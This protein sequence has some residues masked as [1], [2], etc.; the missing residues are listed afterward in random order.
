MPPR[1]D[2]TGVDDGLPSRILAGSD[3]PRLR[4]PAGRPSGTGVGGA[5]MAERLACQRNDVVSAIAATAGIAGLAVPAARPAW[6]PVPGARAR[7]MRSCRSTAGRWRAAA[8]PALSSPRRP[9]RPVARDERVLA[10]DA[11]RSAAGDAHRGAPADL[12]PD[13]ASP[14]PRCNSSRWTAAAATWPGGAASPAAGP[15]ARAYDASCASAQFFARPRSPTTALIQ[16]RPASA[17]AGRSRRTRP[18]GRPGRPVRPARIGQQ[19]APDR[20][21]VRIRRPRELL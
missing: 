12:P 8:G 13:A 3:H 16:A 7:Q 14:V 11:G 9:R 10:P 19:R 4:D 20:H 15:T 17:V 5:F 21:D 2:R 18:V 6:C 1:P